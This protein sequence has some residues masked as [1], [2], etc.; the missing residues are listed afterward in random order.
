MRKLKTFRIKAMHYNNE[1][2]TWE[3]D[4]R[5]H[6]VIFT[7]KATDLRQAKEAVNRRIRKES[8]E[9]NGYYLVK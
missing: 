3:G 4:Q 6:T 9:Y 5:K 7:A 1:A 8:N 2:H